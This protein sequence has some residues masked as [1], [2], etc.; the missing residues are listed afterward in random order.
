MHYK[1]IKTGSCGNC[2]L[3]GG[4]VA[5]DMGVSYKQIQPYEKGI[6]I[7][8]LTHIH[9]DHFN[10]ATIKKLHSKR[11]S[12]RFACCEWLFQD[13]LDVG[14]DRRVIDVL[15]PGEI[16]HYLI[17]TG[18]DV[19][20]ERLWHNVPNCGYH[21]EYGGE[22]I[23]YATDTGTLDGVEAKD[24]DLYMV[25][26]NHTRADIESRFEKKASAEEY[27]YER[28][29]AM[30]HLSQEQAEDFIYRNIGNRGTYVFLHQHKPEGGAPNGP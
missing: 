26:A 29:A 15:V 14:V 4:F 8:L 18:L 30:Y 12:V 22:K 20:A 23:F 5:I 28:N 21:L 13:L 2:V 16:N 6:K 27:A 3:L 25:E 10:K 17:G 24:Y 7:V 1:I 19:R 11:P 9:C